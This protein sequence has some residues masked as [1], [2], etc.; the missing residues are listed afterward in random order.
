MGR[1]NDLVFTLAASCEFWV[2]VGAV[3]T[4]SVVYW[5]LKDGLGA[6]EVW[7]MAGAVAAFLVAAGVLLSVFCG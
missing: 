5:F 1:L 2:V 7:A 3:A 4:A 6:K